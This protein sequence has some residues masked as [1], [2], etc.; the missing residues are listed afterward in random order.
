[1]SFRSCLADDWLASGG[2][3]KTKSIGKLRAM[4]RDLLRAQLDEI[5]ALAKKILE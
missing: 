4:V 3:G 2:P 5:D 1:M